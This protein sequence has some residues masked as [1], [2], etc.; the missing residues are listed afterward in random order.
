MS[1]ILDALCQDYW[2]WQMRTDPT[3]ATYLGDFRYNDRLPQVGAAD[4]A[5]QVAE[6][7]ELQGRLAAIDVAGLDD[8]ARVSADI[9]AIKLH[10]DV[11]ERSHHF[12]QWCLD[13]LFG[14]QVWLLE[15][16]NYHPIKSEKDFADLAARYHAFGGFM[17][18][19]LANLREGVAQGR[20][21]TRVVTDR[22]IG[23]LRDLVATPL[24]KSPLLPPADFP[25]E[26]VERAIRDAV[27]PAFRKFL[28]FLE[29]G[30][31][32]RDTV[33][34]SAL[35][36]GAAAYA[37]RIRRHTTTDLTAEA[38]HQIGLDMLA[39]VREEM[40]ALAREVGHEGDVA[41][42]MRKIQDDAA[43]Y[44]ASREELL[45]GYRAILAEAEAL[46][47]RYFGRL[48]RV[49]CVVKPIEEYRERD[50]VA[51]YYYNPPDDFS[52][53][54]VYYANTYEPEKRPRYN[55][56]A[57]TLHEAVPGHHTQIALSM[58]ETALP[59]FR[60]HSDFNAYI[61]GWALY[62]ERLGVEMGM[63]RDSLSRFGMLMFG[64]WRTCRLV[65]DTGMHALGWT[66]ERAI[67]FF[68]HNVG[69]PE[70]EIL[71]EIDR[72]IMWPGQALSYAL[73][74]REILRLRRDA[75][76]RLGAGFDLRAFHDEVLR[77]GALPLSTLQKVVESHVER[78]LAA[79]PV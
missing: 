49:G 18:D 60:R 25:R 52:R 27:Y 74:M 13:Q 26:D 10:D 62:A 43:N 54:G 45:E 70:P 11:A 34:L 61:E 56:T 31:P 64:A 36:G 72:Y 66:R 32:A 46:L 21:A 79:D 38:I 78:R 29:A 40:Q 53:P 20:T 35:P 14:P 50:C 42:F 65:V 76:R 73:G 48:P 1:E 6:L 71:N 28:E 2:E 24:E 51:A 4:R 9:L 5:A 7:S 57:L 47:P 8:Q 44:P 3:T 19:Y 69:L 59:A 17:D 68:R 15:L 63:Y 58:E 67:E 33:G 39:E 41:S 75:E 55:M 30:Y 77:Y 22:V 37:F 16:L 23:Q 12:E